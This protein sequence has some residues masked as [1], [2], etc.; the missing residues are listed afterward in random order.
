MTLSA[1]GGPIAIDDRLLSK[2]EAD[3]SLRLTAGGL[4]KNSLN[5]Y[6]RHLYARRL[7][8][9]GLSYEQVRNALLDLGLTDVSI[10]QRLSYVEDVLHSIIVGFPNAEGQLLGIWG[11]AKEK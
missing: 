7:R 4:P 8:L 11:E 5:D 10:G 2:L 6:E 3:M 1:K 9:E